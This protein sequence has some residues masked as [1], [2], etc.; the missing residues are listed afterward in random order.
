VLRRIKFNGL[1]E[2]LRRSV[3]RRHAFP[4]PQTAKLAVARQV[5]AVVNFNRA[6]E[7]S[8]H[9]RVFF[10][11]PSNIQPPAAP[12]LLGSL[13]PC[14]FVPCSSKERPYRVTDTHYT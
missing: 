9:P 3:D 7:T 6:T 1:Q 5:I 13:Q 14:G 11:D 12:F 8:V 10:K 4:A 2:N